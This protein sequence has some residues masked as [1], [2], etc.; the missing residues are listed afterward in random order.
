MTPEQLKRG[1]QSGSKRGAY[2]PRLVG[3][4]AYIRGAGCWGL[5]VWVMIVALKDWCNTELHTQHVIRNGKEY[6]Y[7]R[8]S[9]GQYLQGSWFFGP[10]CR[11]IV[12]IIGTDGIKALRYYFATR[13][14][15][16]AEKKKIIF[17]MIDRIEK[18][19]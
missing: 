2:K 16:K 10:W 8:S 3:N 5:W 18:Y 19:V 14:T 15:M 17:K 12:V 7:K 1:G 13:S 9:D 11:E 4:G 6:R